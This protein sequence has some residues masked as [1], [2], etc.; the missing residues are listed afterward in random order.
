LRCNTKKNSGAKKDRKWE[1]ELP[2]T[3]PI[4][5]LKEKPRKKKLPVSRRPKSVAKSA[6][7][8]KWGNPQKEEAKKKHIYKKSIFTHKVAG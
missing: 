5:K 6:K 8:K 2:P 1:R 3:S 7:K 4:E